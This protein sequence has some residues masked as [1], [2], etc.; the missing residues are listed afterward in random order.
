MSVEQFADFGELVTIGTHKQERV[1][2][3]PLVRP[4]PDFSAHQPEQEA[5]QYVQPPGTREGSIQRAGEGDNLAARLEDIDG[6]FDRISPDRP[7]HGVV[8]VQ[9]VLECLL[10]VIDHLIG[11]QR[12]H[13]FDV[14]GADGGAH[15][16]TQQLGKLDS[17]GADATGSGRDK[18]LL[19][20]LQIGALLQ[21]LP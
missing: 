10:L 20:S 11:P 7:Q 14:T 3:V 4:R 9:L 17:K 15:F 6:F 13:Q 21:C 18:H 8:A 12:A 19:A 1:G 2:D 16:G 5:E